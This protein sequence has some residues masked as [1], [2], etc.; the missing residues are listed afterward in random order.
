[1]FSNKTYSANI[2]PLL[3]KLGDGDSYAEFPARCA[4]CVPLPKVLG[5]QL[6]NSTGNRI[7]V[8]LY[9]DYI[10]R[11]AADD[12]RSID[13]LYLIDY[14]LCGFIGGMVF[15]G[16]IC[17][18]LNR[19]IV[20]GGDRN[21]RCGHIPAVNRGLRMNEAIYSVKKSR[22]NVHRKRASDGASEPGS[23]R[24]PIAILY[25]QPGRGCISLS[26]I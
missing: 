3:L 15:E 14:V 18:S 4:S 22:N 21:Y 7:K 13:I 9:G 19:W 20:R 6:T 17:L 25:N 11:K 2:I 23:T 16:R 1:M 24:Q 10:R 12:G 5:I 26:Q 8:F